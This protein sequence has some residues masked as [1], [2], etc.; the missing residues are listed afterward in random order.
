[1]AK[2]K[3]EKKIELRIWMTGGTYFDLKFK[4]EDD[5]HNFCEAVNSTVTEMLPVTTA[6]SKKMCIRPSSVIAMETI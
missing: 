5:H 2:R 6:Y 1:M 3:K 4:D